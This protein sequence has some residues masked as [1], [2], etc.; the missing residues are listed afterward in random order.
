VYATSF[1]AVGNVYPGDRTGYSGAAYS[2]LEFD[3][4][5]W[6][7]TTGLRYEINAIGPVSQTQRPLLRFGANYQAFSKTF[8]RLSYGEGFRFPTVVER[9]VSDKASGITIFPNPDLA[10]ERGWYTELGI[11]Q[12]FNI[13]GFNATID[14]CVFWMEYKNL[15]DLKFNQYEKATYYFDETGIHVVGEDKVGFKAINRPLSRTAGYELSL[16]GGG[17]IG[18]VTIRTLTGYTYT[19]P[20][21]LS[22]DSSLQNTGNYLNA[23]FTNTTTVQRTDSAAYASLLPYRNRQVVKIDVELSYKKWSVGYNSQYLSVFEKI[24]DALYLVIPGLK[25]FQNGIG[26][27]DWVHN[28]RASM[29]LTPN[30]TVAALVNNVAN[31]AYAT[32]PTRLEPMRTFIVQIRFNF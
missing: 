23:F 7:L 30:L 27:G 4:K 13:L 24:D 19:Y 17:N 21:D 16:E 9:Y 22:A 31:H 10:T 26:S 20:V 6:N 11:K 12:G 1:N 3:R 14:G 15:I 29:K 5:R 32:R 25:D 18:P 2:Q 28:I 8:V